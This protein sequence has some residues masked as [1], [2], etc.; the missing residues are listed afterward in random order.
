MSC[1]SNRF[2]EVVK[3][4]GTPQA[5]ANKCGLSRPTISRFMSGKSRPD[6][7]SLGKIL[8]CLDR[9][10]CAQL[11]EAHL[12]DSIPQDYLKKVE[13][14]TS[15]P[16]RTRS[17]L[18]P[19]SFDRLKGDSLALVLEVGKL[20]LEDAKFYHALS[21]ILEYASPRWSRHLKKSRRLYPQGEE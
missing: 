14:K 15:S 10:S 8:A 18:L 21:P 13:I 2:A 4:A 12:L 16:K 19:A 5:F 17:D 11:L 1:F 3:Q 20:L 7:E 6:R 9:S